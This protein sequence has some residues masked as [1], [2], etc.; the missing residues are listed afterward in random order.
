M[1]HQAGHACLAV[2]VPPPADRL[3]VQAE[4][5]TGE[6][7]PVGQRVVD[8]HQALLDAETVPRWHCAEIHRDLPFRA[9]TWP[10]T[11]VPF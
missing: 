6:S 2:G 1:R 7:D 8:Y 5:P 11:G 9:D 4:V 3:P 10:S